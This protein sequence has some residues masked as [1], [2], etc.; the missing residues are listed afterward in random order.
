MG[1]SDLLGIRIGGPSPHSHFIEDGVDRKKAVFLGLRG[2]YGA[3][4][5]PF[6]ESDLKKSKSSMES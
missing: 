6:I 1:S 3:M 5:F 4:T 2:L